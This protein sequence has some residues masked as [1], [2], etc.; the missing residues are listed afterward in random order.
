MPSLAR[1]PGLAPP[2]TRLRALGGTERGQP[3]TRLP[4]SGSRR[5]WR[6]AHWWGRCHAVS[7]RFVDD[8]GNVVAHYLWPPRW[9]GSDAALGE[10]GKLVD[11]T[12]L[13]HPVFESGLAPGVD[14]RAYRDGMLVFRMGDWGKPSEEEHHE[15]SFD[16]EVAHQ[17]RWVRLMNAH[18]ACL[19]TAW[20]ALHEKILTTSIVRPGRLMAVDFNGE[21]GSSPDHIATA[22][23]NA[24]LA[25]QE[26]ED[27]WRWDRS[28]G[29][30]GP[31]VLQLA[32]DLLSQILAQQR[33]ASSLLRTELLYRGVV[34]F[35]E[36]DAS[37]ALV[38]AWT[39]IEGLLGDEFMDY[40]VDQ[41]VR[42]DG[43]DG[44]KFMNRERRD[45]LTGSGVNSRVTAEMLS[46]ADRIPYDLYR[47]VLASAKARNRWLHRAEPVAP[48][49]A[50][51]AIHTATALFREVEGIDLTLSL[52]RQ[53]HVR[54]TL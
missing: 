39:T 11:H 19:H 47:D 48:S 9:L 32:A 33:Q 2:P 1:T 54:T 20:S 10:D 16:A 4:Q 51:A 14:M 21:F 12:E 50:A 35:Q 24:R 52:Q 53:L 49:S 45:F 41:E 44:S 37:A 18:L 46:L 43:E 8:L 26:D 17:A 13:S 22:L 7:L 36:F 27:D 23:Y 25:P 31:D 28:L 15:D 42:P 6:F 30:I 34:A 29:T 40:L 3:K 38:H 5:A